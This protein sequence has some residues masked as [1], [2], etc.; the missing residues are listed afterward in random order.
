MN[1]DNEIL[2]TRMFHTS[3]VIEWNNEFEEND[4]FL[5]FMKFIN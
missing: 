1:L 3:K 5:L 4:N 2:K